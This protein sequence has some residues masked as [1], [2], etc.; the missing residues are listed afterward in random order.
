[1]IE[2]F[3]QSQVGAVRVKKLPACP[4]CKSTNRIVRRYG[5]LGDVLKCKDCDYLGPPRLPKKRKSR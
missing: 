3:R 1:M 2:L 4:K 5:G